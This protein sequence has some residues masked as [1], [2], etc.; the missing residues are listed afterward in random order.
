MDVSGT[1][2]GLI[3]QPWD[4]NG[5]E[6]PIATSMRRPALSSKS[7]DRPRGGLHKGAAALLWGEPPGCWRRGGNPPAPA[8]PWGKQ[9]R[10]ER[11]IPSLLPQAAVALTSHL[12]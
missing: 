9:E 2:P 4:M 5:Y 10:G 1:F 11:K 3:A 8:F 7:F 12:S 6:L